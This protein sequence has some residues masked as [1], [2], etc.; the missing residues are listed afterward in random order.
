[1]YIESR[2]QSFAGG[3]RTILYVRCGDDDDDATALLA[4]HFGM[5]PW[6]CSFNSI[7]VYD[8]EM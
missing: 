2:D 5:L 1:M 4:R 8:H 7:Y 3:T 6:F